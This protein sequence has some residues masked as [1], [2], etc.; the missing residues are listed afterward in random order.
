[1]IF[2][3][4]FWSKKVRTWHSCNMYMKM[5]WKL[6]CNKSCDMNKDRKWARKRQERILSAIYF[7][8]EQRIL[9]HEK[10]LPLAMNAKATEL[11]AKP[12][13]A[14]LSGFVLQLHSKFTN[15]YRF[16]TKMFLRQVFLPQKEEFFP[17][18]L[19]GDILLWVKTKSFNAKK[20]FWQI[21]YI[22]LM[23]AMITVC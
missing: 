20:N 7:T 12:N 15:S 11:L 9:Y 4:N 17:L 13:F 16:L 19:W 23:L 8:S 3:I 2:P 1:M 10:K 14:T 21:C 18:P 22:W 6:W 5:K